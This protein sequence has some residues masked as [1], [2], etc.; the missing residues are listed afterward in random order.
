LAGVTALFFSER[1]RGR[2]AAD[3]HILS[4]A[5]S[6]SRWFRQKQTP[7]TTAAFVVGVTALFFSERERGR[8]A[9][10]VH[11]LSLAPS[12]SRWFR[13]KANAADNRGVCGRG[14]RI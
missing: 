5:P 12:M 7:R 3:V 9:A 14:D 8:E 11:I 1:E 4:P 6:M 2:E 10:D 13:Q